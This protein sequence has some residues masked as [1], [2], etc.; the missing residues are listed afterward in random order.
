MISRITEKR[1]QFNNGII[2][3]NFKDL[4]DIC[5]LE[6]I[7]NESQYER[8]MNISRKLI[9]IENLTVSQSKYLDKITDYIIEYEDKMSDF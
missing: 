6:N 8:A 4:V 2:P 7:I 9:L 3:T 1:I 5:S